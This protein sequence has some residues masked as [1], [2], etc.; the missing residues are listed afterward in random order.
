MIGGE[1][2]RIS[3]MEVE[4]RVKSDGGGVVVPTATACRGYC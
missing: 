2:K 1:A 3:K 4:V